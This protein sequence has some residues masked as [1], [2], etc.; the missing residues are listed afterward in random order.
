[1][2]VELLD[3]CGKPGEAANCRGHNFDDDVLEGEDLEQ[4][5]AK[6]CEASSVGRS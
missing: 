2:I 6:R 3:S 4:R 1:M 5:M